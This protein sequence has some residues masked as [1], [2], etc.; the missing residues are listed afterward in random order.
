VVELMTR[1]EEDDVLV[2]AREHEDELLQAALATGLTYVEAG[3]V[4][5]VSER[6]VRRRMGH[7][8]FAA[9]VSVRRGEQVT[10]MTGHLVSA[11]TNA[12]DVLR[13]CLGSSN[14]GVR[15]RAAHLI[16]TLGPQLR[17]AHELEER[18]HALEGQSA[19]SSSN[20]APA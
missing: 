5:G 2:T 11:G 13:A 3:A 1:S 16:L 6:T 18:L 17:H 20:E 14:D 8:Q 10:V 19:G 7:R 15:L 4:A 9:E 12:I